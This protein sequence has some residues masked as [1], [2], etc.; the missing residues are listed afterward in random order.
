LQEKCWGMQRSVD[1][2]LHSG[3]AGMRC[4][5]SVFAQ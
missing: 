3:L 4:Y 1:E 2:W 5:V